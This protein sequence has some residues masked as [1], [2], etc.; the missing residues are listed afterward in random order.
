VENLPRHLILYDGLC[1]LC[2]RF[3]A[4][5]IARDP[6]GIFHF[7]SLQGPLGRS[8]VARHGRRPEALGTFYLVA[9]YRTASPVLLDK[10]RAALAVARELGAPWS[11]ATVLGVLPERLL[12]RAYDA[13][14]KRRYRI[15]GRLE[16]CLLPRPEHLGRFED[17]DGTEDGGIREG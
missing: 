12:N 8:I 14:A 7:A 3:V 1:G 15:F 10:T 5:V 9:D 11:W 17:G 16:R 4:F 13:V 2:D 6:P